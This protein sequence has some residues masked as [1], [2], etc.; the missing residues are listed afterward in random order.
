MNHQAFATTRLTH[1]FTKFVICFFVATGMSL[2]LFLFM[3]KLINQPIPTLPNVAFSGFVEL[4][5]PPPERPVEQP[6][7]PIPDI[8]EPE[9]QQHSLNALQQ[10]NNNSDMHLPDNFEFNSDNLFPGIST[11]PGA[12]NIAVA[13]ELLSTFGEDTQQGF[14]EVT[15][16]ATRQPNIPE[17][18]YQNQLNGWVLVIFKVSKAGK[19]HSIKVLDASPKGIFEED[20][21]N[22][23]KQWRYDVRAAASQQQ[24]IV[25]TQKIELN[26]QHYPQ[27]SPYNH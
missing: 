3:Q 2:L 5:Q 7:E 24:D 14:I 21:I 1:S 15:P 16:F 22:A 27:N 19:P 8:A 9:P 23:I 20:V 12:G 6:P 25:M 4:F 18:A 10:S 17:I 11:G 13:Q 26:W